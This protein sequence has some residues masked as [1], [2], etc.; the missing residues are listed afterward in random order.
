MEEIPLGRYKHEIE[1][2]LRQAILLNYNSEPWHSVTEKELGMLEVVEEHLLRALVKGH[3]K[4]PLEFLYLKAGAIPIRYLISCRR[5]IHHQVLLRETSE[6]TQRI[7]NA[8]KDD[9]ING[10]FAHLIYKDYSLVNCK[11]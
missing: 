11:L 8:Q 2:R 5:L 10:D 4:T 7:Y 6:L 3:S 9:P 1:L